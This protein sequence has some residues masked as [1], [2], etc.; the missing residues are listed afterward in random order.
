MAGRRG[1][2][3]SLHLLSLSGERGLVIM[4]RPPAL[5]RATEDHGYAT[6]W[7]MRSAIALELP[8]RAEAKEGERCIAK[9]V[10]L[11]IT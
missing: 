11:E 10:H 6:G 7:L 5:R 8:P 4:N 1:R 2:F 3:P 9:Q